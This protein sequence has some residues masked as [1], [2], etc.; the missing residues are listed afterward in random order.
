[1]SCYCSASHYSTD[2][3]DSLRDSILHHSD[4][5]ADLSESS[6]DLDWERY[7]TLHG[8]QLIWESWISKYGSYI[9]PN[10]LSPGSNIQRPA[11][12]DETSFCIQGDKVFDPNRRTSF[13]GLLDDVKTDCV[14]PDDL[15]KLQNNVETGKPDETEAPRILVEIVKIE[16]GEISNRRFSDFSETAKSVSERSEDSSNIDDNDRLRLNVFSRCS[17]SSAPLSAT[18]DSMT[19]VTRMTVSSSDSSYGLDDSSAKSSLILS[20][21][22]SAQSVDQQWQLLWADHF[23]E[24]YNYHYSIFNDR[25]KK[26]DSVEE[27]KSD[28]GF[29]IDDSKHSQNKQS[30]SLHQQSIDEIGTIEELLGSVSES[31]LTKPSSILGS[32]KSSSK[33][34]HLKR[35]CHSQR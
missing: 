12:G 17:G 32:S 3:H 2:E 33:S 20:S 28:S 10:Y 27:V 29:I 14:E 13:A 30:D 6:R 16:T 31:D 7:W 25:H 4:S 8:E 34:E 23:N 1:M 21:S 9:D 26:K 18:T 24:Q 19:N 35:Y 15:D 22:D 5:G 11:E